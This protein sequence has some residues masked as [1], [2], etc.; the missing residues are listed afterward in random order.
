M[1]LTGTAALAALALAT[2]L[3]TATTATAAPAPAA[4]TW[5]VA[6]GP[7]TA[8]GTWAGAGSMT[9]KGEGELRSTA[10]SATECHSLWVDHRWDFMPVSTQKIATVC[11]TATVPVTFTRLVGPSAE[12]KVRVCT[13]AVN[14]SSCG[15]RLSLTYGTVD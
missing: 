1:R 15:P 5:T 12:T 6:Q 4:K 10:A 11:G 14:T 13:G 7:A 2:V 8:S 9:Y 3:G